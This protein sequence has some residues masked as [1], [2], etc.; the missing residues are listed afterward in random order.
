MTQD[1]YPTYDM[2]WGED[3]QAMWFGPTHR[4]KEDSK[5]FCYYKVGSVPNRNY[6]RYQKNLRRD[7]TSDSHVVIGD[8]LTIGWKE[9][10]CWR[11]AIVGQCPAKF[12]PK[13]EETPPVVICESCRRKEAYIKALE[14]QVEE[15]KP[16]EKW[17]EKLK[18]QG[19]TEYNFGLGPK[20]GPLSTNEQIRRE[21]DRIRC[22][23]ETPLGFKDLDDLE[24]ALRQGSN[25]RKLRPDK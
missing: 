5:I 2:T 16:D 22:D 23:D 9:I 18:K 14:K 15:L 8:Y 21:V 6:G 20:I 12:C 7:L 4:P 24:R 13:V 19:L 3:V 25:I 10:L 11:E 17:L 1:N